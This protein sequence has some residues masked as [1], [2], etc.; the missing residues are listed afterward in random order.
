[1]TISKPIAKRTEMIKSFIDKVN[2]M[3]DIME[4]STNMAS[5]SKKLS[6][7]ESN[8]HLELACQISN[9]LILSTSPTSKNIN[10][11]IE[12]NDIVVDYYRYTVKN[13]SRIYDKCSWDKMTTT[14]QNNSLMLERLKNGEMPQTQCCTIS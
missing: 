9:L 10:I 13:L 5:I 11:L 1:M 12:I 2:L 7:F 3:L 8:E 14:L 4:L 6:E